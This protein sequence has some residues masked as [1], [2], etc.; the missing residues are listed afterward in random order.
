MKSAAHGPIDGVEKPC[1]I[2]KQMV[3]RDDVFF[4]TK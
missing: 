2:G 1:D 4:P 3:A